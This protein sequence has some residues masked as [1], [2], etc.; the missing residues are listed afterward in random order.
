MKGGS[1]DDAE[2]LQSEEMG[3]D[4]WRCYDNLEEKKIYRSYF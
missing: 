2:N 1:A 4:S 3:L